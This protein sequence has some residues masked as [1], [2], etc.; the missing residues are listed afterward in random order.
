VAIAGPL[1]AS[2]DAATALVAFSLFVTTIVLA[3]AVIGNDNLQDLKT[4]HLVEATPMKQQIAL[5]IGVVAGAVV[6]PIVLNVMNR[7]FG[8]QGDP[9]YAAITNEPLGAPQATLISSLA[10]G[11]IGGDLPWE[12]LGIGALIGCVLIS[13][14]VFLRSRTKDNLSL[15]PLGV[16]LAIYLPSAV[17]LPVI[18]GA[19]LG[20]MFEKSVSDKPFGEKAKR[21][22]T[23]IVSGFIVGESL[24]NVVLAFV[25][26]LT[27]NPNPIQ[28][29]IA[30]PEPLAMLLSGGLGLGI[31]FILYRWSSA[32]ASK[33]HNLKDAQ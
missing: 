13:I 11:V 22:A 18:I 15:P 19:V 1:A 10:K 32:S 6:I 27:E 31:M 8:F 7:S 9:N 17:T 30:T 4:G 26:Y 12:L 14:D 33:T 28:F 3:V 24:L 2:R 29:G 20:Y 5:L 23:L 25:I 16:G 21:L